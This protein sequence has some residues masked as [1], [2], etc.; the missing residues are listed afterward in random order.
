LGE[1]GET[2][3]SFWE[4]LGLLDRLVAKY[5]RDHRLFLEYV[6]REGLIKREVD[7]A[8]ETRPE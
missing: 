4:R 2:V 1:G 8:D 7:H 6:A 3:V 5:D